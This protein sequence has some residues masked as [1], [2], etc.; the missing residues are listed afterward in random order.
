M[1]GRPEIFDTLTA[2][3]ETMGGKGQFEQ[4]PRTG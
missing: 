3:E 4:S 1:E 2:A